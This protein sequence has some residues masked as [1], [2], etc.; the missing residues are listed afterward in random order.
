MMGDK[1]EPKSEMTYDLPPE[2]GDE[3]FM[4]GMADLSEKYNIPQN[5]ILAMMDFETGGTFDQ[6]RRI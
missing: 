1:V 3:K 2:V 5:D 4:S 6:H